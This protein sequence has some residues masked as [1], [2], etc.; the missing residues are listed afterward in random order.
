[1]KEQYCIFF[2]GKKPFPVSIDQ[3]LSSP[4]WKIVEKWL[5]SL[6]DSELITPSKSCNEN[7]SRLIYSK[8]ELS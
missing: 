6:D 4:D 8:W 2:N 1:M 3:H 7:I 5:D